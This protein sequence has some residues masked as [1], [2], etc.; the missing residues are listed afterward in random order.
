MAQSNHLKSAVLIAVTA[1]ATT[2]LIQACGGGRGSEAMAQT[3]S[4]ADIIEGVWE[5]SVTIR[6]CA[7]SAAIRTFKGES[8]MHRGGTLTSD[9]SLPPPTRGIALGIWKRS[10]ASNYTAN[11]RFLRFNAD[12]SLAGSQ[13][14][15]RTLTLGTDN[16][17]LSGTIAGQLLD[18][19]EVVLQ[20][21]CG[22]ETAVRIY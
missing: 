15:T 20:P 2:L 10:S 14:V 3:A 18:T 22:T 21:I 9:N 13:K 4:E 12:G 19:A 5:S 17:T 1:A 6:D 11:F 16:N 7:T 8:M